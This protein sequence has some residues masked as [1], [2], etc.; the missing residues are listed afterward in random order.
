[1]SEPSKRLK[2]T[3][4]FHTPLTHVA[5]V[6]ATLYSWTFDPPFEH[7]LRGC[8]YFG[9]TRQTFE[10][11][12]CQHKSDSL[13]VPK[14]LG[15][16]AL[17]RVYPHD[18]HWVIEVIE[19]RRFVDVLDAL[20]WMN[21]EEV[22]L[23]DTHGG[24]LRDAD[25]ALKQTLNLTRG[26]QGD[27]RAVWDAIV[28]HSRRRLSKIW[29]KFRRYYEEHEHLR[30]PFRDP[31]LGRLVHSIRSQKSF[32]HHADFKGWL[33]ERGF[34]YDEER[35]HLDLDVWPKFR[36]YYEEHEHL[37]VPIR[38]PDLGRLVGNIR[39]QKSF[40]HHTDFAMW[41]WSACF[42]MHTRDPQMNCERWRHV[43]VNT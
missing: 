30:V 26:G 33:D 25:G 4:L 3:H 11:R 40:L 15:L 31:D 7:A 22:R 36:R 35:A 16:H 19:T 10:R 42:E 14:E 43:F 24:L 13:R 27:P 39:S 28:L 2:Q 6:D 5:E 17:W 8:S 37:R 18:D 34:V 21:E 20:A 29:P 12:T 32:L 41:L 1:M 9:Q 38:D 23:I